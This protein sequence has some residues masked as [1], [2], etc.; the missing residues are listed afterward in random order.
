MVGAV[1]RHN[2]AGLA[3][4]DLPLA[5]GKLLPPTNGEQLAAANRQLLHLIDSSPN[6]RDRDLPHS[7]TLFQVWIQFAHRIGAV[8]VSA[9]IGLLLAEVLKNRRFYPREIKRP[10]LLLL[11]LLATQIT[12]GVLTVVLRKPADVASAHV[13]VGALVL[14]TCFVL[15]VRGLRLYSSASRGSSRPAAATVPARQFSENREANEPA[16]EAVTV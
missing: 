5:Y 9:A 14:V 6:P 11:L 4:P 7:V 16:G 1:M 8:V 13:A 15:S 2:Q 12:L 10:A 3:I